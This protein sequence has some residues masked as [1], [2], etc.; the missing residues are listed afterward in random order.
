VTRRQLGRVPL[1]VVSAAEEPPP[2]HAR[3]ARHRL[4]LIL[5]CA[6]RKAPSQLC[7]GVFARQ[8]HFVG[9]RTGKRQGERC[10]SL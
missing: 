7:G 8:G 1:P 3:P 5:A 9:V 6:S 4:G 10:Q 2:L